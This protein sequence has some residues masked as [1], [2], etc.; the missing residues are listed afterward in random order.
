[1]WRDY[2]TRVPATEAAFS[3]DLQRWA[4]ER[5][6]E[7]KLGKVGGACTTAVLFGL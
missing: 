2:K 4:G 3:A 6:V 1:M 5:S 7:I